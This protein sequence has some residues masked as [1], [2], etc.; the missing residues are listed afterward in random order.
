MSILKDLFKTGAD[1]LA[2]TVGDAFDQNFTTKE[3]REVTITV[4]R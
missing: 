4:L 2:K 1:K 3:E